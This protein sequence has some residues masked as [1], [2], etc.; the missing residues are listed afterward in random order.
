MLVRDS[1]LAEAS[2]IL[3]FTPASWN[4]FAG[5]LHSDGLKIDG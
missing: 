2:P 1:K 5:S 3:S 4:A